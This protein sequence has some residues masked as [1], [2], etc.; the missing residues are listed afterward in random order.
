[1]KPIRFL[2]L[3]MSMMLIT[4]ATC[5]AVDV[6]E[7]LS[8]DIGVSELEMSL[9]AEA[10]NAYGSLWLADLTDIP[11]RLE[12]LWIYVT[13]LSH[14]PI[15]SAI[16]GGAGLILTSLM[17]SFCL[18]FTDNRSVRLAG[19][20][21]IALYCM[22]SVESCVSVAKDT[23]ES[24]VTFSHALLPCLCTAAAAGG[25]VTSAGVKY[26]ASMLFLDG[27]LSLMQTVIL[28]VVYA[29]AAIFLAGEAAGNGILQSLGGLIRSAVKWL[30]ILLTT[31]FTVYLSVSGILSGTV[32][33]SAAK[34]AKT[35]LSASLPVVGGILSD[36]SSTLLSGAMILRN[37]IGLLGMLSVLA[38]CAIPY[39]TLGS[40][41]L[42]FQASG[43]AA[44]SFCD[45]QIGGVIRGMG[46]VFGILLGMIGSA[47]V[48]LFVSI[49]SLM[50]A[51]QIG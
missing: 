40:H 35:V 34:A 25:A 9:P 39:L 49:I 30:L 43:A 32:D 16:R 29:Y 6:Q 45:L 28:P 5:S 18:I 41:Y 22:R 11:D 20:A 51:V 15:L 47:S 31:V 3:L 27:M 17:I 1:M 36:A 2:V 4:C 14:D 10:V 46:N 38:V 26:A 50:Q 24:L 8:E 13:G 19:V 21:V 12:Q 23:M 37:G 44:S 42:V 48:M 7:A 33:A